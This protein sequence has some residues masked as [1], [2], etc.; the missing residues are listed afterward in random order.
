M[1]SLPSQPLQLQ[2][3]EQNWG[4][5]RIHPIRIFRK[6]GLTGD[7]EVS[8][9]SESAPRPSV[10]HPCC[11]QVKMTRSIVQ[12][13]VKDLQ[14][15]SRYSYKILIDFLLENLELHSIYRTLLDSGQVLIVIDQILTL[16]QQPI[17]RQHTTIS[18]INFMTKRSTDVKINC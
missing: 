15:L 3:S 7:I 14:P 4:I 12:N 18:T 10:F 5:L 17:L 2:H 8:W 16:F 9:R 13:V 11:F 1:Y 6:F